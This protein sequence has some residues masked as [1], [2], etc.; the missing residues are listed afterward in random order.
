M[1]G[2][3]FIITAASGA[4]K[5]SLVRAL[6][7]ADANIKL[8]VSYTTRQPRSGEV[9]GEHYH[10]VDEKQFLS[11]LTAGDFLE[12]AN[13][14]GARYGTSQTRVKEALASG[15]DLIL[16]IDWQGAAEVRKLYPNA[17]SI[18]ILPPSIA[19]LESR[20]RGR[21]QDS[22]EVIIKRLAASA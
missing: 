13:V 8:S 18:F 10:F 21:G 4:G 9:N 19:E 2:H 17:I 22:E 16:E 12:S 3:L 1:S 6:L 20:L 11:M 5:T 15:D 7:A 14:H